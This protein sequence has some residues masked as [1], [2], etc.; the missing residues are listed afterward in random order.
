MKIDNLQIILIFVQYTVQGQ[1]NSAAKNST[2]SDNFREME[3][4]L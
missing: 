3:F 1:M 2:T 4:T